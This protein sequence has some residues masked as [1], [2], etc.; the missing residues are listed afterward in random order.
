MMI[1]ELHDFQK[2]AKALDQEAREISPG[3]N[4][5]N[6]KEGNLFLFDEYC[7]KDVPAGTNDEEIIFWYLIVDLYNLFFDAGR[8][9]SGKPGS[10]LPDITFQEWKY[11]KNE[12]NK[13]HNPIHKIQAFYNA[14]NE[15]RSV[16]CHNKPQTAFLFHLIDDPVLNTF[17]S[18]WDKK[19]KPLQLLTK[20]KIDKAQFQIFF[21]LFLEL[22]HKVL[23]LIEKDILPCFANYSANQ[24]DESIYKNWF[25]PIFSWYLDNNIV[26]V[27]AKRRFWQVVSK[28]QHPCAQ[29]IIAGRRENGHEIKKS[30][31]L[32]RIHNNTYRDDIQKLKN[33]G[34]NMY[35]I[36][37]SL[38]AKTADRKPLTP[39]NL[40]EPLLWN[41]YI[42]TGASSPEIPS[43]NS[44]FAPR[45]KT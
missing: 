16:F 37:F 3:G 31:I 2:R 29:S 23:D 36:H 7:P 9:L 41:H 13:T 15:I 22:A 28:R 27:R 26:Y 38:G 30:I 19:I 43:L 33:Y 12:V 34:E 39:Y 20:N 10:I 25:C 42:N 6:H 21:F 45:I 11:D 1:E 5:K 35:Y 8:F 44:L 17:V 18:D 24:D 14:L 4:S 32:D 40:F